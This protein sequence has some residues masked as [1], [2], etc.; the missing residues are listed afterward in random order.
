MFS[1]IE[2]YGQALHLAYGY[3]QK[4]PCRST[5]SNIGLMAKIKTFLIAPDASQQIANLNSTIEVALD[6]SSIEHAVN[7]ELRNTES[8]ANENQL[9]LF[10]GKIA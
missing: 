2:K 1:R 6:K 10:K 9:E 8:A 7:T 5:N 3:E 4:A